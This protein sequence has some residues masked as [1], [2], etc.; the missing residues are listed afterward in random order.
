MPTIYIPP[1]EDPL[2]VYSDWKSRGWLKRH[3]KKRILT[4]GL[5]AGVIL[6]TVIW[7]LLQMQNGL[8]SFSFTLGMG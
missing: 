8:P 3:S 5:I 4:T 1:G 2:K 6:A 7:L